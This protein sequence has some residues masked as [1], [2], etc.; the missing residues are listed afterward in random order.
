MSN[1]TL[2]K[3]VEGGQKMS[4]IDRD[5]IKRSDNGQFITQRGGGGGFL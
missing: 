5:N 2:T 4:Y 1:W 3:T